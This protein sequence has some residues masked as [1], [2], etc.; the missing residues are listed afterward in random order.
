MQDLNSAR[1]ALLVVVARPEAAGGV[2]ATVAASAAVV[3]V[4]ERF[5]VAKARRD[6]N[7]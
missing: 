5:I 2:L 1:G 3:F 4:C 6:L 7:M